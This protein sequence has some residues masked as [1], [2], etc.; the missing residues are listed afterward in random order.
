MEATKSKKLINRFFNFST[1]NR[2]TIM[3]TVTCFF[4]FKFFQKKFSFKK[5]N[6]N[7]V[8]ITL[9]LKLWSRLNNNQIV[10]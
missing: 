1:H 10:E 6:T 7:I 3:K 9:L 4:Y 5:R 8:A 2:C